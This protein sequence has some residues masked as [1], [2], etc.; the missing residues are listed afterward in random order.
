MTYG[1]VRNLCPLKTSSACGLQASVSF[2]Q[3]DVQ[4]GDHIRS[5][6]RLALSSLASPHS[7]ADCSPVVFDTLVP[8]CEHM[9]DLLARRRLCCLPALLSALP[10]PHHS[11]DR[12]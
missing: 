6:C 7:P 8:C 10:T 4:V 5:V 12:L 3:G 11:G 2:T 1:M 9:T